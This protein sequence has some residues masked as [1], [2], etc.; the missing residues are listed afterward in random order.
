[1]SIIQIPAGL[2]IAQ[3]VWGQQRNDLEFRSI[4][5]A[6]AIEGTG[7]LW[8]ASITATPYKHGQ[9]GM[10]QSL[11]LALRGRVN[12]LAMWNMERPAPAGTMRGSMSLSAAAPGGSTALA[13]VSAGQA[14]KTLLAGDFVGL[15]SGLNQQVVMVTSNAVSNGSGVITINIEPPLRY[16]FAAGSGIAWDRPTALFRRKTSLSSWDISPGILSNM[17]LDF[18]EDTRP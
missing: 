8:V 5:G 16:S 7:P 9:A 1:M 11:M 12:Q 13:I 2:K 15:G 10:W 6:Q 14:I 18:L 3:Q 17:M 4:F